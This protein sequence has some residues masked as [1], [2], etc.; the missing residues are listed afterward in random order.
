MTNG[1]FGYNGYKLIFETVAGS[2]MYGT[3]T[4]DSDYDFRGVAIEPVESLIGLTPWDKP[5]EDKN[6][7]DRVIYPL[8]KFISLALDSNP[9]V[10]ELLYAPKLTTTVYEPE[11]ENLMRYREFFL[12][13]K[14]ADTFVGYAVS[15]MKR[16]ET[17]YRWMTT[18]PPVKPNPLDYGMRIENNFSTM[19]GAPTW[20]YALATE[21]NRFDNDEKTFEN[22]QKW[23]ANRNPKRHAMEEKL[24]YDTKNAMHLVRLLQQ[25]EEILRTGFLTLPR[26]NAA[27]LLDIRNGSMTYLQVLEFMEEHRQLLNNLKVESDLPDKPNFVGVEFHTIMTHQRYLAY[28]FKDGD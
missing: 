12:S 8:R 28:M 2:H 11:W 19:G 21:K 7:L 1:Q 18:E 16:M 27:E 10:I 15:Q 5:H 13:T 26:P 20:R 3:S 4:P 14:A 23:L 9:N 6:Y 24:G 25:G 22:Y 17:H